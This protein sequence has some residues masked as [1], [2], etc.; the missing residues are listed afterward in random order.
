MST[1]PLA[2]QVWG[3]LEEDLIRAVRAAG[4]RSPDVLK[5]VRE[6]AAEIPPEHTVH[7]SAEIDRVATLAF[8][9]D[10][11]DRFREWLRGLAAI[12]ADEAAVT[13]MAERASVER[14][15]A[16]IDPAR[17]API[18]ARL[19][20]LIAA[21]VSP[22]V[23][24]QVAIAIAEGLG[25]PG[26]RF[27]RQLLQSIAPVDPEALLDVTG[28]AA[29][30]ES[31][32]AARLHKTVVQAAGRSLLERA[33]NPEASKLQVATPDDVVSDRLS[34]DVVV[35]G[36]GAAGGVLAHRLARAGRQVLVLERG[37]LVDPDE[38]RD[39]A[40]LVREALGDTRRDKALEIL[41]G[42]CVGGSTLISD[43]IPAPLPRSVLDQW[44]AL[45]G[46][47]KGLTLTK[48]FDRLAKELELEIPKKM[49]ELDE[50]GDKPLEAR[51]L[52]RIAGDSAPQRLSMLTTL[53]LR[54]QQS[55]DFARVEVL[56]DCRVERLEAR[57]GRV[58]RVRCRLSDGRTLV[59]EADTVILAAG[60][61]HSSAILRRSHLGGDAV[62]RRLHFNLTALL[63]AEYTSDERQNRVRY[64][65]SME[66]GY[67]S[68]TRAADARGTIAGMPGWFEDIAQGRST[69]GAWTVSAVTV[70]S[71]GTGQVNVP[72]GSRSR[73]RV[74]FQPGDDVRRL[75]TALQHVGAEAFRNDAQR[76]RPAT[77]RPLDIRGST[78]ADLPRLIS[79]RDLMLT[80]GQPLGG[81]AMGAEESGGVVDENFK[82][83]N[84]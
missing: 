34:A 38:V 17:F 24:A 83:Y 3:L 67:V 19:T 78:L 69:E 80:S 44:H 64:F 23:V 8:D 54:A 58:R 2:E 42:Q 50:P 82:V 35:V 33:E 21:P 14:L 63:L 72:E 81:N 51:Q 71:I 75:I 40:A 53:L 46:P 22:I 28:G 36:S 15:R 39:R 76:V 4:A 73:S 43:G 74:V 52:T 48:T 57:A 30:R 77:H 84:T 70:P 68:L 6:L 31:R 62:G 7:L 47:L 55:R 45:G 13:A 37:H 9:V 66:R 12:G 1:E 5:V 20:P 32:P 11:A 29:E 26:E 10:W 59:V 49:R 61:I 56:S 25:T 65:E 27:A 18:A 16:A 41:Q 60:A 79:G